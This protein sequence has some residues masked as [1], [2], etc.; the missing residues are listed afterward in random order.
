MKE[1]VDGLTCQHIKADKRMI[2]HLYYLFAN[3]QEENC[4]DV[5]V[6]CNDTYVFILLIYHVAKIK[7]I[8]NK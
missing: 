1:E 4:I 5:S 7:T 2:V 3:L 6:W 8:D